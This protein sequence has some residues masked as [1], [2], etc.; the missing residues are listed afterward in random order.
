MGDTDNTGGG[1]RCPA[2]NYSFETLEAKDQICARLKLD[3]E[4]SL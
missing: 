3:V 2:V 4:N 1:G